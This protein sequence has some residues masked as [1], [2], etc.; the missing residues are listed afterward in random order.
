MAKTS[1]TTHYLSFLFLP[2]YPLPSLPY[3]G[4]RLSAF[5]D[6]NQAAVPEI[7][8]RFAISRKTVL[9]HIV[10]WKCIK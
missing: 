3:D 6:P 4:G 5:G 8:Q 7:A 9:Q 10:K 2:F 1:Y